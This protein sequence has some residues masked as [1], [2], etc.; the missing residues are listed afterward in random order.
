M[1]QEGYFAVD[2]Q[3]CA[4]EKM[5]FKEFLE[6]RSQFELSQQMRIQTKLQKL[7][8]AKEQGKSIKEHSDGE[9]AEE[10]EA[11]GIPYL[12]FDL[13]DPRQI[14]HEIQ[15]DKARK[16]GKKLGEDMKLKI[17]DLGNGCWTHH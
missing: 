11:L 8:E 3:Q 5:R 15:E 2:L 10:A 17:C 6:Y 13:M 14:R 12:K 4:V 7:K 1:Q 9:D 16:R